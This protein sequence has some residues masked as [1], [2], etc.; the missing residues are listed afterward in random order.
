M[1]PEYLSY[2]KM[3][4]RSA[5]VTKLDTQENG[6]GCINSA[7]CNFN[8]NPCYISGSYD[9]IVILFKL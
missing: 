4:R 6:K 5:T 1:V 9:M 8:R 7:D 3:S 2:K